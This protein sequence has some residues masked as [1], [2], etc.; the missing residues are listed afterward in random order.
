MLVPSAILKKLYGDSND[1]NPLYG[2][3]NQGDAANPTPAAPL[4]SVSPQNPQNAAPSLSP[5][6]ASPSPSP[7]TSPGAALLYGR[8]PDVAGSAGPSS[9]TDASAVPPR[10][11]IYSSVNAASP[12]GSSAP[13]GATPTVPGSSLLTQ[14]QFAQQNPDA[15]KAYLSARPVSPFDA[16]TPHPKLRHAL[17]ALF[18]GMAEY[19]RPGEG[20]EMVNRW[21]QEYQ[22][23]AN[24]DANL[25]KLKAGAIN[26]AYQNYLQEGGEQASIAG[27][28]A[29][30]SKT[31]QEIHNMQVNPPGKEE[32]LQKFTAALKSG[33]EDP[34]Q[35]YNQYLALSTSVPGVSRD[36]L[37]RLAN[38]T[39]EVP[40]SFKIGEQGIAQ[41]LRYHGQVWSVNHQIKADPKAGFTGANLINEPNAPPALQ[42]AAA[43]ART[44]EDQVQANKVQ[45]QQAARS[46]IVLGQ[47]YNIDKDRNDKLLAEDTSLSDSQQRHD[48]LA[49]AVD[50][51]QKGNVIQAQNAVL[52]TLGLSLDGITKRINTT[53]LAKFEQAGSIG[54]RIA[55]TLRGWT[56]GNPFP[57]SVWGDIKS[58]ADQELTEAQ[59]KHDRNVKLINNRLGGPSTASSPD[60]SQPQTSAGGQSAPAAGMVRFQDSQGGLHDIPKANLDKA[61]QRDSGLKVIQ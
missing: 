60:S 32:F 9:G 51:A 8:S 20:A 48:Q 41:P 25:P 17:S 6:M 12:A 33:E 53:E 18:A 46:N 34:H 35:V 10:G 28:Q 19:G 36:D 22:N 27:T 52:K 42:Q 58:F 13:G 40:P 37:T 4:P 23:E 5:D 56:E 47:Q 50:M 1:S 39:P 14:D 45:S 2:P 43:A 30:T 11:S 15:Y 24:Y 38:A 3:A 57:D 49:N 31:W 7:Q 26:Q 21:D 54:Q 55:G 61:R 16:N 44:D 29:Q 59:Q